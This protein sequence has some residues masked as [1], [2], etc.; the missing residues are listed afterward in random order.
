MKLAVLWNN[1][2]PCN[3]KI[4]NIDSNDLRRNVDEL[5]K[6]EAKVRGNNSDFSDRMSKSRCLK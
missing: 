5:K 3:T 4:Q 6:D 2:C 1:T